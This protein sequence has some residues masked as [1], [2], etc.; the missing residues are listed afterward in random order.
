MTP[1]FLNKMSEGKEL[2]GIYLSLF[3]PTTVE[4]AAQSGY[5][6]ARVDLEH[7]LMGMSELREMIRTATLVQLPVFIRVSS[8]ESITAML[9]MGADGIMVPGVNSVEMAQKAVALTKYAPLGCRG[10]AGSQRNTGFG[11]QKM[12]EY[13]VQA[14]REVML[15]IQIESRE[16]LEQI[17]RILALEGID[18]V[19]TGRL[20]LSQSLGLAGQNDHPEVLAA[21]DTIVR[22]AVQYGKLPILLV[23]TPERKDMLAEKGVRGFMTARDSLL[24]RNAM[25]NN[26]AMFRQS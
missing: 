10:M 4:L 26:V 16:G 12:K 18:M 23:N 6:F 14:N 22:K 20:D 19:S 24:L 21:E 25:R 17:D 15:C 5:D 1:A 2:L 8:L 9:D 3:D 7:T 13:T 11:E